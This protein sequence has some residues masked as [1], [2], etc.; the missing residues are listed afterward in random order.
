MI[1]KR[2]RSA[3]E[4]ARPVSSS[5][6]RT[7]HSKGDSPVAISSLPPIG[8]HAPLLGCLRPVQEQVLAGGV[9]E[10]DEDGDPVGKVLVSGH[11][12]TGDYDGEPCDHEA[13][14]RS[15]GH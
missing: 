10:E 9:L 7:A 11:R 2:C 1:A 12:A 8:L 3:A 14:E 13:F 6:S 15:G 4:T 5:V